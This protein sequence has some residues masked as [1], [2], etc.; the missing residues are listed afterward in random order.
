[1]DAVASKFKDATKRSVVIV[2]LQRL[3]GLLLNHYSLEQM[4]ALPTLTPS[5]FQGTAYQ[6][7]GAPLPF[8]PAAT[9]ASATASAP[10]S[11]MAAAGSAVASKPDPPPS[12]NAIVPA[13]STNNES[14]DVVPHVAKKVK[15]TIPKPGVNGGVAGVL[16]GKRFVLTGVFPEVGGGTGLSLGKDRVTSMIESFG[17]VVT[18]AVSGKTNFLLV[19]AEPGRSKVSKADEK[20]IPLIDLIAL[21]RLLLGQATLEATASAPPP[22]IDSFSAGYAGQFRLGY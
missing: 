15:F 10:R 12:S 18:S 6:A 13:I 8:N 4:N 16:N 2:N 5:D 17:G 11:A 19:G 21:N 22:R 9:S 14:T 7:A 1:M 3:Q 20:G